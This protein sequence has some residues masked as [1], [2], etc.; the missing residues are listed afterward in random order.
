MNTYQICE[1]IDGNGETRYKIRVTYNTKYG[2][3]DVELITV[4]SKQEAK[5]IID[6]LIV[7]DRE[8]DMKLVSCEDYP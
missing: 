5:T 6:R 7:I 3:F 8:K 1:L 2:K 4:K